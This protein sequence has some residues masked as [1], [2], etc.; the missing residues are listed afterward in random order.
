MSNKNIT[1]NNNIMS[2]QNIKL[3]YI[4]GADGAISI[5]NKELK[6]NIIKTVGLNKNNVEFVYNK[7]EISEVLPN[8]CRICFIK[9]SK[10]LPKSD[11]L[12]KLVAKIIEDANSGLYNKI[13]IFGTCY[14]GAIANRIAEELKLEL[15]RQK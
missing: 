9:N 12:N 11:F 4:F 8:V 10:P 3:Y 14:G 15:Q 2:K 7:N 5:E 13:L 6:K 1:S